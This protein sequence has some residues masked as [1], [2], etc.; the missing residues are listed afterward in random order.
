M[1]KRRFAPEDFDRNP[2][3]TVEILPSGNARRHNHRL[4]PS[5]EQRE[6]MI[7]ARIQREEE[8]A[9][10]EEFRREET[11]QLRHDRKM[12]EAKRRADARK[13][14]RRKKPY[15]PNQLGQ[16]NRERNAKTEYG[17]EEENLAPHGAPPVIR[18]RDKAPLSPIES[19]KRQTFLD[20]ALNDPEVHA[21]F[22]F[23]V[24]TMVGEN[25][26]RLSPSDDRQPIFV[27]SDGTGRLPFSHAERLEIGAR[28][29]V[30][31]KLPEESRRDMEILTEQ[32]MPCDKRFSLSPIEYGKIVTRSS[33]E[34]VAKGGY[35]GTF[36]K[37]AHH[38]NQLYVEWE[39]NLFRQ[40]R[41]EGTV[42]NG[43]DARLLEISSEKSKKV[44]A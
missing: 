42:V 28:N 22:R 6:A 16:P 18:A 21:L 37:L 14:P 40:R 34:R 31:A 4:V 23:I 39:L 41:E 17:F 5:P 20:K 10:E 33:D 13:P 32:V 3:V 25:R 1:S 2:A 43:K 24:G 11:R 38:V 12:D 9:A 19:G 26:M 8:R 27:K 29:Y 44:L 35:I 30:Y 15:N 36:K 7:R